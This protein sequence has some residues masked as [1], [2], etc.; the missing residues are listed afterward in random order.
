LIADQQQY[1]QLALH[2]DIHD[3]YHS[4]QHNN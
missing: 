4:L 2:P 1:Q 3:R